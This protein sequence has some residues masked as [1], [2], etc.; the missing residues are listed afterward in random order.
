[1]SYIATFQFVLKYVPF[2][3]DRLLCT[4]SL[5]SLISFKIEMQVTNH[6]DGRRTKKKR[7]Q[8]KYYCTKRSYNLF[9]NVSQHFNMSG[10]MSIW[11]YKKT[12]EDA[13]ITNSMSLSQ[14]VLLSRV[15]HNY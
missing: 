5:T 15:L 1:M 2:S 12:F 4:S 9:L 3:Q 7:R 11:T 8:C 13:I 6:V 10:C 14:G